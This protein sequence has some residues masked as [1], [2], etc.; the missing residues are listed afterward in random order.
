MP[1]GYTY[2]TLHLGLHQSRTKWAPDVR[3]IPDHAEW[4]ELD[5]RAYKNWV[6]G[7]QSIDPRPGAVLLD[8]LELTLVRIIATACAERILYSEYFPLNDGSVIIRLYFIP[9]FPNSLNCNAPTHR[10][11]DGFSQQKFSIELG[12][13]LN[14][15][16]T[17]RMHWSGC[18]G[19]DTSCGNYRFRLHPMVSLIP[20]FGVLELYSLKDNTLAGLFNR[21]PSPPS[22]RDERLPPPV[23]ALAH[24]VFHAERLPGMKSVLHQYQRASI[25]KMLHKETHPGSMIDPLFVP[26]KNLLTGDTFYFQP[27]TLTITPTPPHMAQPYGGI[28][29]EELGAGKTCMLLGKNFSLRPLSSTILKI[30]LGLIL[31]TLHQLPSPED[32]LLEPR[33]VLTPVSLRHFKSSESFEARESIYEHG[34]AIT[35]LTSFPT[36]SGFIAHRLRADP[37]ARRF[38]EIEEASSMYDFLQEIR[39]NVPFYLQSSQESPVPRRGSLSRYPTLTPPRRI[40]LSAATLIIVPPHL[41]IQWQSEIHKHCEDMLRVLAVTS[42]GSVPDAVH[43]ANDFDV[44]L[45]STTRKFAS[46]PLLF[47]AHILAEFSREAKRGKGHGLDF[48]MQCFCPSSGI[49]GIPDCS[50]KSASAHSPLMSIRWKRFIIDEGHVLSNHTTELST[51]AS[52]VSAERRWLVSGTP[53]THLI[54]TGLGSQQSSDVSGNGSSQ[55]VVFHKSNA[56]GSWNPDDRKDLVKLSSIFTHFLQL[57]QFAVDHKLFTNL[58]VNPLMIA[59]SAPPFGSVQIIYQVLAQNIVRHR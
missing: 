10:T 5:K 50:C 58:V 46:M 38:R 37:D 41:F 17:S 26:L 23:A 2:G 20:A 28:L 56:K 19:D 33:P 34:E 54:G 6:T 8:Q 21:L 51:L 25:A 27:T 12:C 16:S 49:T 59:N 18:P 31:L 13:L 43:L 57:P 4:E 35:H 24:Q 45:L 15:V 40:F 44:I 29:G 47:K 42:E 9:T 22:V 52:R 39:R 53:T 48:Y 11:F 3:I 7:D 30:W 55:L 32:S 1:L 14:H 36:L